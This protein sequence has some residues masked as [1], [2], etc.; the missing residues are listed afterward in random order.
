MWGYCKA[1]IVQAGK[2]FLPRKSAFIILIL[3]LNNDVRH[4]YEIR[5]SSN[6]ETYTHTRHISAMSLQISF[7]VVMRY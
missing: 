5:H 2:V 3:D 7:P 4:H 1:L 6:P